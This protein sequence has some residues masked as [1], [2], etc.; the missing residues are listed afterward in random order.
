[1]AKSAAEQLNADKQPKIVVLDAN[2]AGIKQGQK[3]FVATPQ[4][5]DQ[6]IRKIPF[7]KTRTITRLRREI[8]RRRKCD[9]TC[10]VSTAIFIRICAQAAIDEFE[11][12]AAITDI[13]PFWRLLT[14]EDKIA[15]KLTIDGNWIDM[16]REL[17]KNDTEP[18]ESG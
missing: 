8:A 17:E 1:M 15:K 2:F 11:N 5:I 14:S 12:G 3:L 7:G 10:P 4:I 16:Q 9:A 13:T 6:Y 18:R